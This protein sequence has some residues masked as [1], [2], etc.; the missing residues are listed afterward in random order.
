MDV[1]E[2][3]ATNENQVIAILAF[4]VISLSGVI[5][6]QWLYTTKK[7]VPKWAWDDMVRKVEKLLDRQQEYGIIIKEH[8]RNK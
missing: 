5:A 7:T 6:T 8:L 3:L 4:L 2:T 1:L